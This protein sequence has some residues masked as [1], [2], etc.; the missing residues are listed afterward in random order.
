MNSVGPSPV[1]EPIFHVGE[2]LLTFS[3][4]CGRLA[5]MPLVGISEDR[6]MR[7]TGP[8]ARQANLSLPQPPWR[9]G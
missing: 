8:P 7:P 3:A 6:M 9:K 2:S 5:I 4:S 1:N